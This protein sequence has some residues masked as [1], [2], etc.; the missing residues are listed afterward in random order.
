MI[1]ERK[2]LKTI[3]F[4]VGECSGPLI[5][6]RRHDEKCGVCRTREKVATHPSIRSVHSSPSADIRDNAVAGCENSTHYITQPFFR[7]LEHIYLEQRGSDSDC[8]DDNNGV[9][10][11]A[12]NLTNSRRCG[13][14]RGSPLFLS[15]GDRQTAPTPIS[16]SLTWSAPHQ[17]GLHYG[18]P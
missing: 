14:W 18:P 13:D 15:F 11:R 17:V 6:Q 4:R 9:T 16:P 2:F 3:L 7:L 1:T 8:V 12:G 5:R 10:M